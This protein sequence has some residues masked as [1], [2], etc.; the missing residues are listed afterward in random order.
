MKLALGTTQF[1]LNYG[2]SNTVGC[3]PLQEINKILKLAKKSGIHV[4]DT[5]ALY[6]KSEKTLGDTKVLND[7]NIV[8]KTTTFPT[9]NKL[10][11][12]HGEMITRT[13]QR[14]LKSLG[15]TNVY[16]LLIH[17]AED[18]LKGGSDYLIDAILTLKQMNL[19]KKIGV[20]IYYGQQIDQILER[21]PMIDIVQLPLNVLDQRL[22][23]SGHLYELKKKNIE[24]HSRSTFLQGLLLMKCS[25][26]NSYFKPI[27]S[28]LNNYFDMIKQ[29][30]LSRLQAALLFSVNIKEIQTVLVGVTHVK[31]LQEIL[32]A[33]VEIVDKKI[34]LSFAAIQDERFINP[35]MWAL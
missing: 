32:Q 26:M 13:F 22:I 2:I 30:G 25:K 14:S 11:K 28:N 31:E 18:L 27:F 3:V 10:R 15:I 7:F 20:S 23:S 24:I 1:G 33:Y 9:V 29:Y 8:T 4:L 6:G 19:V 35:A 12:I 5:A 16:G 34:D 21:Y 17:H